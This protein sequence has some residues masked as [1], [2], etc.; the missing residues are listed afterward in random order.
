MIELDIYTKKKP[1][2]RGV[3]V[4]V[5]TGRTTPREL[6]KD[7]F[8]LAA[9]LAGLG[10]VVLVAGVLLLEFLAARALLFFK[11]VGARRPGQRRG[12]RKVW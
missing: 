9:G 5:Y 12:T 6:I 8:K 2:A 4:P 7:F 3:L 11:S 10:V 1:P